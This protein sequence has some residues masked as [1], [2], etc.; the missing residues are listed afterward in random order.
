MEYST[1]TQ[2]PDEVLL[3]NIRRVLAHAETRQQV[4]EDYAYTFEQLGLSVG[5]ANSIAYTLVSLMQGLATIGEMQQIATILFKSFKTTNSH[6]LQDVLRDSHRDRAL[7]IFCQIVHSLPRNGAFLDYGC[8]NG[9]VAMHVAK[10]TRLQVTGADIKNSLWPE[11]SGVVAFV[12]I[13]ESSRVLVSEKYEAVLLSTVAHHAEDSEVILCEAARLGKKII[14][15]ETFAEGETHDELDEQ[16]G[17]I[18]MNDLLWNRFF[19]L[20]DTPVPGSY[21]TLRGWCQRMQAYGFT[22]ESS[23]DFSYDQKMIRVRH[24]KMVF[25]QK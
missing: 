9:L 2:A 6:A 23:K 20:G 11:T 5:N 12:A 19:N 14:M 16:W 24:Q 8:G 18:F 22:L 3:A 1:V 7:Q 10:N 25:V 4:E 15:I 21:D 17:R 13:D